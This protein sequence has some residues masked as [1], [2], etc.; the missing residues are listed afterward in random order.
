LYECLASCKKGNALTLFMVRA[1]YNQTPVDVYRKGPADFAFGKEM[2][3]I[4]Q[5]LPF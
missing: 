5:K 3:H 1:I 2:R 4:T